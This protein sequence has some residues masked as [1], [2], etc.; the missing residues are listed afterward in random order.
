M[1]SVVNLICKQIHLACMDLDVVISQ[2]PIYFLCRSVSKST[3]N[4]D[5]IRYVLRSTTSW[6]LRRAIAYVYLWF[7]YLVPLDLHIAPLEELS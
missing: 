2:N 4:L 1:Q 7:T 5:L 3:S 6:S